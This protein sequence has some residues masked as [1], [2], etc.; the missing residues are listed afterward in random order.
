M[1]FKEAMDKIKEENHISLTVIGEMV[2]VSYVSMYQRYNDKAKGQLRLAT[3][4][5][6]Y[7]RFGVVIDPYTQETLDNVIK[8]RS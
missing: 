2:G 6:F 1:T 7:K 5:K 8:A 3:A 4:I